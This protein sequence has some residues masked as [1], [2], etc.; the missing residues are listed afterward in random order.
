LEL[1]ILGAIEIRHDGTPVQLS[2]AKPR[3]LLALLA[4]RPNRPIT[5]EQLIEELWQDRAPPSASTALRVHMGRLRQALELN[6][7]PNAP[8]ARLPAGPHGYVLRIEPDELDSQHFERLVL[9]ACDATTRGEPSE[10]VPLLTRALDLWR[11]PPLENIADRP[12]ARGEIARLEDLRAVAIEELADARLVLGEHALVIDLVGAALVDFPLR[13]RLTASHMRALYRS[14]RQA[15]ALRTYA[16]LA[17]R[18]DEDLGVTPSAELRRLEEDILLQR[19]SLDFAP[20]RTVTPTFMRARAP[21]ARFVGRRREVSH[22]L[23]AYDAACAGASKLVLVSG[24]AGQ[25]K[26]T[27]AEEFCARAELRGTAPL[28]GHCDSE[29]TTDY[30]PIVEILREV[31]G[32]I[33]PHARS[34]LPD[35]LGLVLPDLIPASADDDRRAGTETPFRLFESIATTLATQVAS[36]RVLIVEDLHWA[37]RPT[38]QLLRHLVRFPGLDSTLI[39]A[40]FRDDEIDGERAETIWRLARSAN[41]SSVVLT[42]FDD[43]EVRAL[44]R[45]TA[46]PET[47][48]TL[49]DL[50]AT[51]H[52]ITGGNPFFLRELLRDLDELMVKLESPD[53]LSE[54][55]STIA[56]VGVRALVDHRFTALTP[57]AER[58][59]SAAATLGRKLTVVTLAA[60]CRMSAAATREALEEGLAARLLVEDG[61]S[62]DQYL[63]PHALVRN[64]VYARIPPSERLEL[65]RRVAQILDRTETAVAARRSA[66]I[67]H[68]FAEAAP[69]GLERQAAVHAQRAGDDAAMRLAFAEAAR[70]YEQALAFSAA[71]GANDD[72]IGRLHLALGRAY[73]QDK[74]PEPAREALLTAA[75]FARQSPDRRFLVDVAFAAD[76]PWALGSDYVP[77]ALAL[78]EEAL[79]GVDAHDIELRVQLLDRIASNLYYVDPERERCCAF[80]ALA[81]AECRDAPADVASAL[82]AVHLWYTH[83]PEARDK[84]LAIA[85]RAFALSREVGESVGL[86]LSQRSL[87]VDLLEGQ[88]IDEFDTEL[89]AYENA[90][91]SLG[92]P[93]DIYWSMALRAAQTTMHGDLDAGEQLA[94]GAMLRGHELDQISDGA[95]VLQRFVVRYQQARLTEEAA[96]LEAMGKTRSVYRAGAS[97]QAVAFADTGQP[98]RAVA[99]T[100]GILGPD[101]SGL[102]RD[103]FWLA[104]ACLFAGA[105]ATAQDCNTSALLLRLLE[106]CADHVVLFGA[107]AAMLGTGHQWIGELELT[108]GNAD[109]AIEHL[110]EAN[111]IAKRLDAPFWIAQSAVTA[112]AALRARGR[113]RDRSRVADLV[114]EANSLA[115]PLRYGRILGQLERLG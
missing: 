34:S 31:V 22:L 39:I 101:G 82:R 21:I 68:H 29:P 110:E 100:R 17:R 15:E 3:Q 89:D 77:D 6:R 104:G 83:Q 56:P 70:W 36:P 97:L 16:T 69:L 107:G 27:L 40:T 65:H 54:A 10:A 46:P 113:A 86:L 78:L 115:G 103:A 67:A 48:H 55:L 25:G 76:S 11:G 13:E 49:V 112:A 23:D 50:T 33:D 105:M 41:R 102:P 35:R 111:A 52:D 7:S 108:L 87:L 95:Y 75:S 79:A 57:N 93:H 43:H 73:A 96:I 81:L 12:V 37:N 98:E 14:G 71:A 63:F 85:R 109:S 8:S 90:S 44:V 45:A 84:R 2:G 72:K 53:A 88:A 59:M 38:L 20:A 19:T 80:E 30:Q 24:A 26:T 58:V 28:V 32:Q 74:R 99:I 4:I 18:L 62:L 106:P 9:L 92:S 1:R 47:L 94:R 5:G 51:L 91:R 42:G 60:L 61:Q 114:A 66:E 64:A